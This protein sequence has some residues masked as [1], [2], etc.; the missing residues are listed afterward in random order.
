MGERH[1]RKFF[2]VLFILLAVAS[3]ILAFLPPLIKEGSAFATSVLLVI[4][5]LASAFAC[6]IY[7][8]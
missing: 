4:S 3:F 7:H 2:L 8:G 1:G 5:V 6:M